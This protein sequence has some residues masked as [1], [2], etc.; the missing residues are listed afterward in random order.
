V[1]IGLNRDP[2]RSPMRWDGM[3]AGGF[4]TGEPWLPMGDDVAERNVA[5][6]KTDERSLLWLYRRLMRL[7]RAEPALVAGQYV[8]IRSRNG[9][10]MYKRAW[11]DEDI[12]IALNTTHQPRKLEW[13]G[14][15]TLLL[16]T[17]LNGEGKTIASPMLLRA[18]EGMIVKLQK[19]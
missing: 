5:K 6:L 1:V 16:S 8:P 4:T 13:H 9:I 17:Y 12:L 19:R 11:T 15:G 18:D 3:R 10:L 14:R 7:R 2:Q